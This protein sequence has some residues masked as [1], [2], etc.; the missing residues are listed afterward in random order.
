MEPVRFHAALNWVIDTSADLLPGGNLEGTLERYLDRLL[1]WV[2]AEQG[3]IMLLKEDELSVVAS[4]GLSP[5]VQPGMRVGLDAGPAGEVVTDGRPR[6]ITG[7]IDSKR[8]TRRPRSAMVIPIRAQERIVG[9]LNVG[10]L[11]G[12]ED[13]TS[14]DL[15]AISIVAAQLAWILSNFDLMAKM[16]TLAITDELTGLYNRRYFTLRLREELQR[17]ERYDTPLC[18]VMMDLDG[19]KELN[20]GHGHLIGDEILTQVCAVIRRNLRAVDV[21]ARFGG[22]EVVVLLPET[23]VAAG[24]NIITRLQQAVA[25]E[26]YV[27]HDGVPV[28]LTICAGIA[29]FPG[30]ATNPDDLIRKAD[31]ALL[32]AKAVGSGRLLLAE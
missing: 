31:V 13:F 17:S 2:G 12:A 14:D 26:V 9:V 19:F 5:E 10:K 25:S 27:G 20:R 32:D 16:W 6:L 29:Q 28:K 7:R 23:P 1:E 4:R 18:L 24:F 21:P 3:S 30:D 8:K 11:S 22:D 15:Q